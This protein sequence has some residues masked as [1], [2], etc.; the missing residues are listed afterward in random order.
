MYYGTI[1]VAGIKKKEREREREREREV[2]VIKC[3][4]VTVIPY[5]AI[6]SSLLRTCMKPAREK[7]RKEAFRICIWIEITCFD[8]VLYCLRVRTC[9]ISSTPVRFTA[10]RKDEIEGF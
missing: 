7:K 4:C 5:I 2:V 8:I 3:V 10:K 1:D 9:N 6:T